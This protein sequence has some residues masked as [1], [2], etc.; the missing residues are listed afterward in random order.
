MSKLGTLVTGVDVVTTIIQSFVPQFVLIGTV[1][2]ANVIKNITISIGGSVTQQIAGQVVIG[3]MMKYLMES[4]LGADV[5]IGLLW[6]VANSFMPKQTFQMQLTNSG[7]SVPDIYGFSASNTDQVP[8]YAGQETVLTSSYLV[9]NGDDFD[10]LFFESTN[11]NYAILTF[12]DGHSEQYTA[13]ELAALFALENQCDADGKL[14]GAVVIDN[15]LDNIDSVT[16]YATAGGTCPVSR[17]KM[18]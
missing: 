5:K 7:A 10:A 9:F 17:L 8:V 18:L 14:N 1:D 15:K 2:L 16:V 11:F 12:E 6:K 3:A 13:V 4:L